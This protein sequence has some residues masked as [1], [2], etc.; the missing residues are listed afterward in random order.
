MRTATIVTAALAFFA[1]TVAAL[2]VVD[3]GTIREIDWS[4]GTITLDDGNV[5]VI[6][7]DLQAQFPLA[8]GER[9]KVTYQDMIASA[10]AKA[11]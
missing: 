2:A 4:T 3:T 9:V 1:S 11:S 8:L 6:P 10:L 5:C 7:P